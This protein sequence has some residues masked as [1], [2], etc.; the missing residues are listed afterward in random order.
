MNARGNRNRWR[1]WAKAAWGKSEGK[2][3]TIKHWAKDLP[4]CEKRVCV[5]MC[6]RP[7]SQH[8]ID[9][10]ADQQTICIVFCAT[11]AVL[12]SFTLALN[13]LNS[14]DRFTRRSGVL[15]FAVVCVCV[16][17]S[18]TTTLVLP[19]HS[20][21]LSVFPF[22]FSLEWPRP[23]AAACQQTQP[24]SASSSSTDQIDKWFARV[25]WRAILLSYFAFLF[26]FN[27]H[28]CALCTFHSWFSLFILH[29]SITA[30]FDQKMWMKEWTYEGQKK[31]KS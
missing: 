18:L 26:F 17:V 7:V 29:Y 14:G 31:Q 24:Q 12:L 28:T 11:S 19:M 22:L 9:T 4:S 16:C 25:N 10:A 21:C 23:P 1:R 8:S 3:W 5:C 30:I 27:I 6:A 2:S 13:V 15:V 20:A